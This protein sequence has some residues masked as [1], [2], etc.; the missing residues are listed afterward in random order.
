MDIGD[1]PIFQFVFRN[2]VGNP[3]NPTLVKAWVREPDGNIVNLV[4]NNTAVGVY[5]IAYD[6][7]KEG[8]HFIRVEGTGAVKAAKEKRFTVTEKKV[9]HT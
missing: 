6:V 4:P 8:E 5:E 7:T 3:A 1:S 9:D 2:R